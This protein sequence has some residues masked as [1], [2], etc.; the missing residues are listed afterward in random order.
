MRHSF[1]AHVLLAA[2]QTSVAPRGV[3]Q[4]HLFYCLGEIPVNYKVTSI[5][6]S[7]ERPESLLLY[8]ECSCLDTISKI[9]NAGK[10]KWRRRDGHLVG[11]GGPGRTVPRIISLAELLEKVTPL[12]KIFQRLID[13]FEKINKLMIV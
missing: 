2:Y 11:V 12:I 7:F 6:T 3:A 5:R 1:V 10:T 9:R 4:F 8:P 13:R